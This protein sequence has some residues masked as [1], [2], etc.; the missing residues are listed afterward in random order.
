MKRAGSS[1]ANGAAWSHVRPG[2]RAVIASMAAAVWPTAGAHRHRYFY[3]SFAIFQCFL[4]A[5]VIFGW[6]VHLSVWRR[7]PRDGED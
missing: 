3:V 5:G 6:Y 4:G 7:V 2:V 1:A